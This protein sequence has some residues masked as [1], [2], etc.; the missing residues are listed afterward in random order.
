L[1]GESSSGWWVVPALFLLVIGFRAS[2]LKIYDI[3]NGVGGAFL[4]TT[5][6]VGGFF[7]RRKLAE[8]RGVTAHPDDEG[9]WRAGT[10]AIATIVLIITLI[11]PET[12]C[13][14]LGLGVLQLILN[15]L[16][17]R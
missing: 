11:A 10:R 15:W 17:V 8:A 2:G 16:F 1:E 6:F 14:V 5:I 13:V 7:Q 3:L 12:I 4:S 9:E